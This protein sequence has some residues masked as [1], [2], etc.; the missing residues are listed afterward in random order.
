MIVFIIF[1]FGVK[2]L[3]VDKPNQSI[4]LQHIFAKACLISNFDKPKT[5]LKLTDSQKKIL[6]MIKKD[7]E[8]EDNIYKRKYL[9][10]N[11]EMYLQSYFFSYI[12]NKNKIENHE[13]I[14]SSLFEISRNKMA[15]FNMS[16]E[17]FFY[18]W[19]HFSEHFFSYKINID[20]L[21]ENYNYKI[22]YKSPY[23]YYLANLLFCFS[24]VLT[25]FSVISV[26]F[27]IILKKKLSKD[28]IFTLQLSLYLIF[29]FFIISLLAFLHQDIQ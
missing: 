16:L 1:N 4:L 25:I 20:K 13:I 22:F 7:I 18:N 10:S 27:P 6:K 9:K 2:N 21:N 28:Y 23:N 24:F 19:I 8:E 14:K 15:Y 11:Y 3:F 26:F 5:H 12:I 29:Y 17:G